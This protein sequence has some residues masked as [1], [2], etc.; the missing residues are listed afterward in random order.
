MG[1]GDEEAAGRAVGFPNIRGEG[2]EPQWDKLRVRA[3]PGTFWEG[4]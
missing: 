1:N 3:Q 4:V 2:N